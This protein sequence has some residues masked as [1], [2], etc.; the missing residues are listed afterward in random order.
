[1]G[2]TVWVESEGIP[3][4]GTTFHFTIQT[5]P[6]PAIERSYL[7]VMQPELAGR[8]VLI[9]D[10]NRTNRQIIRRQIESWDMQ[11]QETSLPSEALALLQS[12]ASL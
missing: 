1:M 5:R 10:D 2:G 3:G 9:V 11:A 4:L 8:R 7:D 6:A 12:G